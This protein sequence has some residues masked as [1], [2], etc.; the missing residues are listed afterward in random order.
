M[1]WFKENFSLIISFVIGF[2]VAVIIM[3]LM[4]P[5]RIAKLADGTEVLATYNNDKKVTADKLF[6]ELQVYDGG[7]SALLNL[8]DLDILKNTYTDETARDEYANGQVEYYLQVYK[9]QGYTEEDAIRE[10]NAH[11]KAELTDYFRNQY[12][13][14]EYYKDYAKSV[15]KE[16]EIKKYYNDNV[17]EVKSVIMYSS[18]KKEMVEG[19]RSMLKSGKSKEDIQK[20]YP[21]IV[22]NELTDLSF[23]DLVA[24]SDTL[25]KNI[26]NHKKGSYTKVFTD[27]SFGYIVLLV[28]EEGKKPT[29]DESRDDI[30]KV[31][32]DQ[33][34]DKDPHFYDKSLVKLREKYNLKIADTELAKAYE[35]LKKE[36]SK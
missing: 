14:Q 20:K 25:G 7:V 26:R 4:W 27:D 5:S 19:V 34:L 29:L 21:N 13:F 24:Y 10:M 36:Y 28:T 16:K 32:T 30:I 31:L 23:T 15:I 11:S 8:V 9:N 17:S 12:Y 3:G 22:V 2:G 35:T 33:M 18:D 6:K 1:K